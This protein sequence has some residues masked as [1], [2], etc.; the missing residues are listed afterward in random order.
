MLSGYLALIP[1]ITCRIGRL[2]CIGDIHNCDQRANALIMKRTGAY[3]AKSEKI[4]LADAQLQ[5]IG[6]RCQAFESRFA[7]ELAAV[8]PEYQDSALNL[9]HYLA[10][11]ESDIRELQENLATLGLSSLDRAERN[12]MASIQAVR[13]ALGAMSGEPATGAT[14]D[15]RALELKNPGADSHKEAILGDAPD[16]RDVS[17]MV[18]LPLEAGDNY[19]LVK[20]MI[21]AGMSVARIN[22]AH[23]N[24]VVW[25]EMIRNVRAASKNAGRTCRIVMDLAGQKIRTGDLRPGPRVF[26]IRPKRDPMGRIIAARRVRF[27]PDDVVWCGT[28]SAV[29]P[30]PRECIE[31]AHDGDEIRFKDARGKKRKFTVVSKDDKGLVLEIYKGAYLATGMKLNLVR[32]E[33]GEKLAYRF[34]KLPTVEQPI[35]LRPGDTLILT[36]AAIPGAPAVE[37]SHGKVVEPA[38]ISCR[39]PEV[40]N[41]VSKDDRVLLNDGKIAG[42]INSIN[43]DHLEITVKKAK[44]TGSRLRGDRGINFPDSDIRLPGL[45]SA[46]K[47]NLRFIVDHADAVSLSFVKRT[48]DVV[49]LQDELLAMGENN[50]GLIIKIETKDG[51]R[52]LPQLLLTAM[53]NYPIALMIARGDLAVE[54]GWERLAEIQEEILWLCEAARIPVI[55]AT[56]VLERTAKRGQP[57]RAEISDAA[58]SQRAD[59]VMLNKGPH[60]LAAIRMLDNILRRMQGHQNKKPPRMRRL[61][62]S[63]E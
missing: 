26:H 22:C 31:Y 6:A 47:D 56:Q 54:A 12:V 36:R 49:A 2:S 1:G 27:I 43:T 16:G 19:S 63:A 57:S 14:F 58:L 4:S 29:V 35:L 17:I 23:D 3:V 39:Q 8:H 61:K 28:K 42:V 32:K 41:Y 18:T 44:P 30:V 5:E 48:E 62:F 21:V 13:R 9:V 24:R 52:N 34:G 51:F 40:F 15:P 59:C 60:I 25:A 38:H 37:D 46:D 7:A 45:T 11:R 53:R 20:E 10:L 55:W 33:E 50:P